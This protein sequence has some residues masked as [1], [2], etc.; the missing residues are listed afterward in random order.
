M[1]LLPA[2]AHIGYPV[3]RGLRV[4]GV[5][6]VAGVAGVACEQAGGYELGPVERADDFGPAEP[7]DEPDDEPGF[8]GGFEG[9][10]GGSGP[11]G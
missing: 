3:R 8:G 10:P 9:D 4:P 2:P 7:D 11:G 1:D 5:P 6:G